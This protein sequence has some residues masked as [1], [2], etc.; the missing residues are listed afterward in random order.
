MGFTDA[1][2][3]YQ[4]PSSAHI[5]TLSNPVFLFLLY[6]AILELICS[7]ENGKDNGTLF[8]SFQK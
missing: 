6:E 1:R 7:S 8:L 5:K 2:K 4:H 3:Q